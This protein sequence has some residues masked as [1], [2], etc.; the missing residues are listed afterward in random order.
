MS[1]F[2]KNYFLHCNA[3]TAGSSQCNVS[4]LYIFEKLN[5]SNY[6]KIIQKFE[7]AIVHSQS[8]MKTFTREKQN[9]TNKTT[10]LKSSHV[11]TYNSKIKKSTLIIRIR[12][13]IR[14]SVRFIIIF[15]VFFA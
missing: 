7:Q 8:P 5:N 4:R 10:K 15:I 13:R 14:I 6:K 3:T 1:F 9:K 2:K 12:I 11:T